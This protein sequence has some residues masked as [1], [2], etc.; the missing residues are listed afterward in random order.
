MFLAFDFSMHARN[1]KKA[2]Q[3]CALEPQKTDCP[4]YNIIIITMIIIIVVEI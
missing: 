3:N 1:K 2:I 4:F